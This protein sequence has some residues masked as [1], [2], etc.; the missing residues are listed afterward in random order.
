MSVPNPQPR[1]G[2]DNG[3]ASCHT[4]PTVGSP[5]G[6]LTVWEMDMTK[7]ER[8]A[9]AYLYAEVCG[10]IPA[11]EVH[12]VLDAMGYDA[13]KGRWTGNEFEVWD[14]IDQQ[15]VILRV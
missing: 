6:S 1:H 13:T 15:F 9:C 14:R 4:S 7:R 12:S 10:M 5:T 8:L 2:V 3:M 11:T